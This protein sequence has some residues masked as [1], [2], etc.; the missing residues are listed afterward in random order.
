MTTSRFTEEQMVAVLR[1]ADKGTAD[2][3]IQRLD[4]RRAADSSEI[5]VTSS[6]VHASTRSGG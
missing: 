2:T 4:L 3:S 6:Y 5:K 1:E